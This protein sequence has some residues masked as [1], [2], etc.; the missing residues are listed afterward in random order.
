MYCREIMKQ[1][2]FSLSGNM[3]VNDAARKMKTEQISILPI[4]DAQGRLVGV[5]TDRDIVLRACAE[6]LDGDV[7]PVEQIMSNELVRCSPDATL[8]HAEKLMLRHHTRRI[9]LTDAENKLVGLITLTDI[10][11]HQSLLESGRWLRDLSAWRYRV[12]R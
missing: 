4:C 5:V 1:K 8:E 2:V 3:S 10:A 11:Q 9:M 6:S 7:T 12:E